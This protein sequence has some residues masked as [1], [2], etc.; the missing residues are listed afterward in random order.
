[1]AP[2]L[3]G[4]VSQFALE[5]GGHVV[6]AAEAGTLGDHLQRQIAGCDQAPGHVEPQALDPTE[7]HQDGDALRF[8]HGANLSCGDL[9][10][11][12]TSH[13]VPIHANSQTVYEET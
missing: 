6:D 2:Q 10:S 8:G 3:A 7:I 1:L 5:Y 12:T 11:R 9:S 13:S 4:R